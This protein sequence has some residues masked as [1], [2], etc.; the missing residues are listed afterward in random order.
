MNFEIRMEGPYDLSRCAWAFCHFPQDGTDVW[1]P[2]RETLP[3]EYHRLHLV[4]EEPILISVQQEFPLQDDRARLIVRTHPARPRNASLLE[5]RVRWQF[6]G[7]ASLDGF[8]RKARKNPFLGPLVKA[9][10]GVKPLRPSTVFEMAVIALSEQQISLNAA[11]QIRSRL[12][13]ALGERIVVEGREYRAF[14]TARALAGRTV[15]DLRKLSL[16]TRK[17]EYLIDL[18]RKVAQEV[19]DLEGL[20]E[21]SN[22]EVI[23]ALTSLRGFGQWSAEYLL[24]RGLGRTEVVAG[25]DLGIQTLVGKYLGPGRRL[26]E[27]E[28]RKMLEEWGPHKRWVVFYLFCASRLGLIGMNRL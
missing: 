13:R 20:R 1:I 28:L 27:K 6:H 11:I 9:L 2:P 10:Y 3:A 16:S 7:E 18:A 26:T 19:F 24:A 17:A 15:R 22:E 23:S 4:E 12:V 14:P 5:Q 25:G 8:Y 21:R